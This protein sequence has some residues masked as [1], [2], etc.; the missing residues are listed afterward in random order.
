MRAAN[1]K[2][3]LARHNRR[4]R[5]NPEYR[6]PVQ[7]ALLARRRQVAPG[8]RPAGCR[9]PPVA[10]GPPEAALGPLHLRR[11]SPAG[12]PRPD[13]P[14]RCLARCA[15]EPLRRQGLS[16]PDPAWALG[17][18]PWQVTA[19]PPMPA[20]PLPGQPVRLRVVGSDLPEAGES[21]STA[22]ALAASLLAP[23]RSRLAE[24]GRGPPPPP[25]VAGA[26]GW[27]VRRVGGDCP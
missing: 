22:A 12:P 2:P 8:S 17:H 26:P 24:P 6:P 23:P 25:R 21:A 19:L 3:K 16:S 14:E 27:F 15:V 10:V 4:A 1:P 20:V 13:A 7:P 18:V 9:T 11:L 5:T